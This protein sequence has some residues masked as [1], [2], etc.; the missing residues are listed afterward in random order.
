MNILHKN[1]SA[2]VEDFWMWVDGPLMCCFPLRP[3]IERV[4]WHCSCLFL[5]CFGFWVSRVAWRCCGKVEM[6]S[7]FATSRLM[8]DSKILFSWISCRYLVHPKD[9][10]R[11]CCCDMFRFGINALPK[12]FINN[13][14]VEVKDYNGLYPSLRPC[15]F[16][17]WLTSSTTL[18]L[19]SERAKI[20][21]KVVPTPLTILEQKKLIHTI[22]CSF[23]YK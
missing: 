14:S 6:T 22:W 10:G 9:P 20:S 2:V 3:P 19:R 5:K 13:G 12:K 11:I 21:L 18:S 16:D 1:F 23:P 8:S 7:Y 4:F 17:H 15:F